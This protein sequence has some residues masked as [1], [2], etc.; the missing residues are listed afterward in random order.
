MFVNNNLKS[1]TI[2][3][4]NNVFYEFDNIKQTGLSLFF[5]EDN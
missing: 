3:L 2:F 1:W 4:K 5:P